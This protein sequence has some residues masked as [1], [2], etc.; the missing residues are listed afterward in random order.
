MRPGVETVLTGSDAAEPR[1]PA[2]AHASWEWRSKDL[3][4]GRLRPR[5]Q[6]G[7]DQIA[8]K[9]IMGV[10]VSMHAGSEEDDKETVKE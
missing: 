3:G 7:R 2:H 5:C 8:D 10:K 1:S 9:E 6:Q 4:L